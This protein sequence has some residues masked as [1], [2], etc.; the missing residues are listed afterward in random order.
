MNKNIDEFD[1]ESFQK[2]VVEGLKSGKPFLGENGTI[3]PLI[4]VSSTLFFEQKVCV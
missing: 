1:F 3:T 4:K 2:S